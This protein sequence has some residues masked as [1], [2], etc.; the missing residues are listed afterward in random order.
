V[1]YRVRGEKVLILRVLH[2]RQQLHASFNPAPLEYN[3]PQAS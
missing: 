3:W 1:P 2:T